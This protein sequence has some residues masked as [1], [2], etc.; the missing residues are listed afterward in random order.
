MAGTTKCTGC[1]NKIGKSSI[2]LKCS[3][4]YDTYDILCAGLTESKYK[5]L[6]SD[7]LQNWICLSCRSKMPKASDVNTPVRLLLN[8]HEDA[9]LDESTENV[10]DSEEADKSET[11]TSNV[12]IHRGSYDARRNHLL[13]GTQ[14]PCRCEC[15]CGNLDSI[16]AIVRE[17]LQAVLAGPLIDSVSNRFIQNMD[18]VFV[19]AQ[20]STAKLFDVVSI[21][22]QKFTQHIAV[23]SET[24]SGPTLLDV[25]GSTTKENNSDRKTKVQRTP[26]SEDI[27]QQDLHSL[28]SCAVPTGTPPLAEPMISMPRSTMPSVPTVASI[29]LSH[30][31]CTATTAALTVPSAPTD[32]LI[33]VSQPAVIANVGTCE[34]TAASGWTEVKSSRRSLPS[35]RSRAQGVLSGTASPGTTLLRAAE[36]RQYLHLYYVME[37]TTEIQVRDHLNTI[38]GENICTVEALKARGS[39]ASFKLGVPSTV[40]ERLMEPANWAKGICVK[41]W[42][43]NFRAKR[44]SELL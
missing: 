1:K 12:T 37:G 31:A 24:P 3:K 6:S 34:A 22:E 39:Y 36:R 13:Q 30:L 25:K 18:G 41:P 33:S 44:E 9:T 4:C 19:G 21:L 26:T 28:F 20:S 43:Q 32:L 14:G 16:R 15:V 11:P 40:A 35:S 38:C 23:A 29:P 17:E 7:F 42:R 27:V 2:A 5:S 8:Y 10:K